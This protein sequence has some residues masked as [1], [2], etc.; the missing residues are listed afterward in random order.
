ME[1]NFLVYGKGADELDTIA[2]N[3]LSVISEIC[4]RPFSA[5]CKGNP[6]LEVGDA[7]R[8]AT[9]YE[10]VESYIL[11]R[12]LKGIQALRD[13]YESQGKQEYSE[14]VN[15][16]RKSII[17]LKGKTNT[18]ERTVEETK[19]TIT[20]V[21]NGLRTQITQTAELIT[22]EIEKQVDETKKYAKN[23]ADTAESN[24]K[25]DTDKK[26][27]SYSTTT[28]MRMRIRI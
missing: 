1:D 7:V 17:Q 2:Q 16:I 19:S 20:D 9:K 14:K 8:L 10:I 6:C 12:T 13:T 24:A 3:M 23:V 22:T 25:G 11:K 28:E 26:L 18:L 27:Q 5:D 4:F 21:E 15:S